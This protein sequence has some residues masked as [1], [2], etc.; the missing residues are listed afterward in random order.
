LKLIYI[1]I[2]KDND[3]I[4][5]LLYTEECCFYIPGFNTGTKCEAGF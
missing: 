1:F 3:N 5:H 2:Y 4:R